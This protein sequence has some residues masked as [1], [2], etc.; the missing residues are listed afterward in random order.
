MYSAGPF[1][2]SETLRG[3]KPEMVENVQILVNL[4]QHTIISTIQSQEKH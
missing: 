2:K 3:F 1:R 4:L